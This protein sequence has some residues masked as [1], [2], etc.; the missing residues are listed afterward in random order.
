MI[1]VNWA[2]CGERPEHI[3]DSIKRWRTS[4]GE[5]AWVAL[6]YIKTLIEAARAKGVPVIYTTGER[7]PDN[8]DAGSWRWKSTRSDEASG[9]IH[10]DIDGNEIVSMIAPGPRDIVIKKQKPSGFFGTNL[11]SYLSS[12][13]AITLSSSGRPPRAACAPQPSTHSASIIE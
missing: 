4:C 8:W 10:D 12:S 1:D 9:T 5:Q 3:L 6:K 11:A 13:A 7:R 2:F